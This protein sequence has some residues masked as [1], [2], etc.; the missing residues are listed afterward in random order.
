[1]ADQ[2][3]RMNENA[4]LYLDELNKA[5]EIQ[6]LQNKYQQMLNDAT[7]PT[8][9]QQITDQMNEQLDYLREK[10]NLSK[11]DVEY[12]N[13]Q[14][15]IL[16][17]TIALEDARAAKNTM[18]LRRDSQGNYNYVYAADNKTVKDPKVV[19]DEPKA[20]EPAENQSVVLDEKTEVKEDK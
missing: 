18:K 6:K 15:E 2:W 19:T 14:L 20:E 12:A 1:M 11:Y 17:K 16:Q 8:V 10:T 3:E 7:D 13:A 5:Y 9:Q 4:D